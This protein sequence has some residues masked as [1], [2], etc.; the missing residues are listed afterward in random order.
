MHNFLVTFAII[1]LA[2]TSLTVSTDLSVLGRSIS[3]LKEDIEIALHDASLQIDTNE[4]AEGRIVF[5]EVRARQVFRE[6]FELNTGFSHSDYEILDFQMFDHSN[7]TFP[8]YYQSTHTDFQDIFFHP[9]IVAVVKTQ[10]GK[11]FYTSDSRNLIRV[12]SYSY[13]VEGM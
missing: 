12:A 10:T 2:M 13:K 5:D 6:S 11:Y 1:I 8:V 3:Y 9:T 4:L 7:T